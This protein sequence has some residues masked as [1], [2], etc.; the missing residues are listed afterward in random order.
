MQNIILP[1]SNRQRN[2]GFQ[3]Q[4]NDSV[5]FNIIDFIEHF[6]GKSIQAESSKEKGNKQSKSASN[7][8]VNVNQTITDSVVQG[9]LTNFES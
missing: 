7:I 4:A 9:N 2:S 6:I 8:V 1:V 3:I 5:R